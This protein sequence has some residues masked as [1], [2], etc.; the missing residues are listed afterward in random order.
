MGTDP[1]MPQLRPAP[2]SLQPAGPCGSLRV[3]A[4]GGAERCLL[5]HRFYLHTGA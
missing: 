2:P 4:G 3:C 5:Q 1:E